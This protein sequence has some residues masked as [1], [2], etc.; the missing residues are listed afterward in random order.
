MTA[1]AA[2]SRGFALWHAAMRWQRAIDAALQPLGLTHT[3]YLVLATADRVIREQG[4]AVAQLT[5]GESSG[6]DRATI[7]ALIRKLETRGLVDR[8]TDAIDG[9]RWRVILTRRGRTLLDK[10]TPLVEA[11]AMEVAPRRGFARLL[12]PE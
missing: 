9:R 11:T 2:T 6:L 4:D 7:S 1:S 5:I 10:A 3:Q 8:G 12:A